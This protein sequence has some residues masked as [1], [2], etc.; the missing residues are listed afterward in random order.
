[1]TNRKVGPK[2]DQGALNGSVD[3]LAGAMRQ[4]FQECMETTRGVVKQDIEGMEQRLTERIDTTNAN[5]QAR[6]SEQ[7][8]KFGKQGI[9]GLK[10]DIEGVKQDIEGVKQ[11]IVG[12][13]RDI[14]G[15]EKRLTKR[16]DTTNV[17]MQAQF[18]AQEEK[19]GKFIAAGR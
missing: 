2:T 4:V 14:V 19:I 8:K 10:R 1:M 16:I 3:L 18:A 9:D 13:K 12:V 7:D 6:F 11:D 17:N 15:V 5:M